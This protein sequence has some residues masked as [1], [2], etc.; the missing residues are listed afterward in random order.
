MTT[1]GNKETAKKILNALACGDIEQLGANMSDD[2]TYT[3]MGDTPISGTFS[4]GTFLTMVEQWHEN[5]VNGE[6]VFKFGE[7]TAE[8]DRVCVEAKSFM[9]TK[10]NKNYRNEYHFF[11]KFADDRACIIREYMDTKHQMEMLFE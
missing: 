8:D 11:M 2:A 9:I 1:A 3:I 7:V 4:K 10:N 6:F 5:V